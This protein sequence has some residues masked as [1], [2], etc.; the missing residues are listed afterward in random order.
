VG[1]YF[2]VFADANTGHLNVNSGVLHRYLWLL[3][4]IRQR[5]RIC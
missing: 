2:Y 5:E 1:V 4:K 3:R